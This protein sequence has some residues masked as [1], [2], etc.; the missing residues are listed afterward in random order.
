MTEYQL[1]IQRGIEMAAQY[2]KHEP[3]KPQ[4]STTTA[5]LCEL[6]EDI[7]RIDLDQGDASG[8]V[9]LSPP[10]PTYAERTAYTRPNVG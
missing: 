1:G 9:A 5:F 3:Y 10:E 2:C 4:G 7:R 6:A 8:P